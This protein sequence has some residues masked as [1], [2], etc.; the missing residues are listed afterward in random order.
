MYHKFY[1]W[2][3]FYIMSSNHKQEQVQVATA[4]EELDALEKLWNDFI[5][6]DDN[7]EYC[8]YRPSLLLLIP[9]MR[10]VMREVLR[11]EVALQEEIDELDRILD[12]TVEECKADAEFL[13]AD[14]EFLKREGYI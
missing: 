4:L 5:P 1:F 12:D 3:Q 14:E 13:K 7:I 10:E 2:R 11:E 8:S 6:Q 9:D